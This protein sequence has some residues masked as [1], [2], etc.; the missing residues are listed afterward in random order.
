MKA[1]VTAILTEGPTDELF[2]PAILQRTMAALLARY[3]RDMVDVRLPTPLR[4]GTG[5][6]SGEKI[7][8]AAR[9][10][11]GYHLLFIHTDADASTRDRAVAERI[12]PGL[13]QVE[14][15]YAR[16]E[17]VCR[18]IVPVIPVQALEAWV[19][20]D[21]D[22]LIQV[23]GTDLSPRDL[24]IPVLPRAIEQT[25]DPKQLLNNAWRLVLETRGR[26]RRKPPVTDLF[27]P[28]ANQARVEQLQKLS[29]FAAVMQ[30]LHN[31]L[32]NLGFTQR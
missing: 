3:G 19:L 7:L 25:T 13:Q 24:G 16:G 15:A 32:A 17:A 12:A 4:V 2:L 28:V 31:A 9:D 22:V 18:T 20:A 10:A 30:D 27:L 26:R 5:F 21:T 11:H 14:V 29:A 23:M 1:L 6:S 8:K